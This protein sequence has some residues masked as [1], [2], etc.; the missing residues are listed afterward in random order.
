MP[1][2]EPRGSQGASIVQVLNKI[3]YLHGRPARLGIAWL[4]SALAIRLEGRI[5][6]LDGGSLPIGSRP[7]SNRY[8]HLT[9]LSPLHD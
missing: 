1:P 4:R 8:A 7:I 5:A 6:L 9:G 2:A 3:S